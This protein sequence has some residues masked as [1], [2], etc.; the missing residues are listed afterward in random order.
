M[1]AGHL[2]YNERVVKRNA[3]DAI[4]DAD[5][6]QYAFNILSDVD[7]D[8][9]PIEHGE[10]TV[11]YTQNGSTNTALMAGTRDNGKLVIDG[12]QGSHV[13]VN[14]ALN[15]YALRKVDGKSVTGYVASIAT[16]ELDSIVFERVLYWCQET[17]R[18]CEYIECEQ[19]PH[20]AMGTVE[21]MTQPV[22][23]VE[24]DV[25]EQARQELAKVER[26]LRTSQ[27]VMDDTT[28]TQHFAKKASLLKRIDKLEQAEKD[29][30]RQARKLEQ[31]KDDIDHACDKGGKWTVDERRQFIRLVTETITL[32]EIAPGWLHLVITWSPLM[33]FVSPVTSTTRAVDTLYL[34]RK[35]GREWSADEIARLRDNQE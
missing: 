7:L 35:A 24:D 14:T 17:E 29:A 2:V 21:Q 33:G 16:N 5:N 10:K 18:E 20:L 11:R 15:V 9:T 28:L 23:T 26:A 32:E 12:V 25:L 6:W 4:V 3:H 13:Y 31:A 1:Y 34:W 22:S 30:E 27:H 19:A 8:G